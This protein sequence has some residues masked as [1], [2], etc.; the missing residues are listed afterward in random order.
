[1]AK[2]CNV[3]KQEYSEDLGA[4]PH[5]AAARVP[6]VPPGSQS[7]IN[8]E[9]HLIGSEPPSQASDHSS[10]VNLG[11]RGPSTHHVEPPSSESDIHLDAP[12]VPD[13]N[14]GVPINRVDEPSDSSVIQWSAL[15]QDAG[16]IDASGVR[17]DSPSDQDLL[18]KAGEVDSSSGIDIAPASPSGDVS[19]IQIVTHSEADVMLEGDSSL[20]KH[21]E[22]SSAP[23]SDTSGLRIT[24]K[25]EPDV[26][27]VSGKSD[28]SGL[29]ITAKSEP[30]VVPVSGKS[31]PDVLP[32]AGEESSVVNLGDLPRKQAASDLMLASDALES[33]A[34]AGAP[35]SAAARGDSGQALVEL[36]QDSGTSHVPLGEDSATGPSSEQSGLD[37]TMLSGSSGEGSS[38]LPE[39]PRRKQAPDAEKPARK[40]P[41]THPAIHEHFS[42]YDDSAVQLGALPERRS[43]EDEAQPSE[44]QSAV[45]QEAEPAPE[46]R[47]D[48]G[49]SGRFGPLRS[50][51]LSKVLVGVAVGLV[52]GAG[53]TAG[54]MSLF[55]GGD[56]KPKT[57]ATQP[58]AGTD[59]AA[60]EWTTKFP[61]Q[62]PDEVAKMIDE[63]NAGKQKADNDLAA[64]AVAM[65][66]EQVKSADELKAAA[67][68][69]QELTDKANAAE[70]K[71]ADSAAAEEKAK[72]AEA[73]ASKRADTLMT[74]VKDYKT[75]LTELETAG[76][77]ANEKTAKLMDELKQADA[78][79]ADLTKQIEVAKEAH[80]TAESILDAAARKL[81]D[82]KYLKP[83]AA[84]ADVARAVEQLIASAKTS[85]PSGKLA[86]LQA[87][88]A[89][90]QSKLARSENALA[91]R[92]TP[93][94]MLDVWLIVLQQPTSDQTMA[95]L[96]LADVER[97]AADTKA[98]PAIQAKAAC[99]KGLAFRQQGLKDEA[100]TVL[101]EAL[102]NAPAEAEWPAVARSAL[103][104]KP[105]PIQPASG[106]VQ[107][108]NPLLAEASYIAGVQSYW[109][110][111]YERAEEQFLTA[112]RNDN[113][114]A[115][116]HYYL[117]LT[118]LS[119]RKQSAAQQDFERGAELERQGRPSRA[120]VNAA[121]ERIQGSTRQSVERYRR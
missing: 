43:D 73:A 41:G 39:R 86:T 44:K 27:P 24:P 115:R 59:Q 36:P 25:S 49:T 7:E 120:A 16:A 11:E 3:C 35:D 18:A 10:V 85:D 17:V 113:R 87:D 110:G 15:A 55:G 96:A 42:D 12:R 65:K 97:V 60:R 1:M 91:Q 114:D 89:A 4:C 54:L 111:A 38:I 62:Q 72:T 40:A 106:E 69:A 112:L 104:D 108:S 75:K 26:V 79:K 30:D 22:P 121:L 81:K 83:D 95:K 21:S 103:E 23:P 92:W 77:D 88:L 100:K 84:S 78:K 6:Q 28:T 93:Q 98:G 94:A 31:E 117:G 66:A 46:S 90:A 48:A 37:L 56:S 102:K 2:H 33:G 67:G 68:K 71:A 5:C 107:E 57:S 61:N 105:R 51:N 29:R 82:G 74:A 118:R 52:L 76:R 109:A 19:G 53:G 34:H 70:K 8:L 116:Y 58:N 20:H 101:A 45:V 50:R 47:T 32:P 14:S 9:A 119:L 80:K 99:V 13:S 63:L 64:Q